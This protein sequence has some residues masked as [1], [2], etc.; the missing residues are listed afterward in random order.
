M[1]VLFLHGKCVWKSDI[2]TQREGMQM[3]LCS[4]FAVCC[5]PE[6]GGTITGPLTESLWGQIRNKWFRFDVGHSQTDIHTRGHTMAIK[7]ISKALIFKANSQLYLSMLF[8]SPRVL[9]YPWFSPTMY[10]TGAPAVWSHWLLLR[11]MNTW[12]QY[13]HIERG[14]PVK[15]KIKQLSA[16]GVMSHFRSFFFLA[17]NKYFFGQFSDTDKRFRSLKY[18]H[19]YSR[20]GVP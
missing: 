2:I 16:Q 15:V 3:E 17:E 8:V 1:K 12:W 6:G 18:T 9:I 4:V 5:Q 13:F 11:T 10:N 19:K 20:C 7:T 14:R